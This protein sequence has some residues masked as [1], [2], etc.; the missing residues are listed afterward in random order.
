MLIGWVSSAIDPSFAR[1][2]LGDSYINMTISNIDQGDPMAV[3]GDMERSSM[4][5]FI[6]QNNIRVSFLAFMLGIFTSVGTGLILFYNGIM[7]GTFLYFFYERGLATLA[8]STIFIHGAIEISAIVI[9]GGAGILLGN[10][11]LFP[12]TFTRLTALKRAAYEGLLIM[13]SLI[14]VFIVAAFLESY[15]TRHYQIMTLFARLFVIVSS[16]SLLLWYYLI[17]SKRV[18]ARFSRG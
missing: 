8:W 1:L 15:V 18:Y 9:A 14:P 11:L 13:I 10:S 7:L 17:Y 5:F 2:I 12:G 3:Y 16:M 6:G 4:F